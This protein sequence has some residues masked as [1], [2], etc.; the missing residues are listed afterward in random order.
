MR[1]HSENHS[2]D[3]DKVSDQELKSR[4]TTEQYNI[5][6]KSSTEKAFTGIYWN[7]KGTGKYHCICCNEELFA[8][9]KKFDSGTGWPSF[10]EEIN[11][12]SITRIEDSS[13]GMIRTEIQCAKCNAHLGHVFNDGPKPSGLRY[14]LNSASLRFIKE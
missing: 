5:T 12:N 13:H 14:C 11:Q 2:N 9:D 8:S 4:L 6:Q 1:F 7:H 3:L 10:W